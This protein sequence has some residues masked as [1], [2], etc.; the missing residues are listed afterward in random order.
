MLNGASFWSKEQ[1]D[2]HVISVDSVYSKVDIETEQNAHDKAYLLDVDASIHLEIM[3][4]EI[5][6]DGSAK[7]LRDEKD[8]NN[9]A[10]ALLTYRASKKTDILPQNTPMTNADMCKLING[11]KGPTHVVSSIV[12]GLRAHFIFDRK[13][14]KADY[15]QDI[16]GKLRIKLN[17]IPNFKLDAEAS[18]T[19]NETVKQENK[20]THITFYG[21]SIVSKMPGT[22]DQVKETFDEINQQAKDGN[23][24]TPIQYQLTPIRYYCEGIVTVLNEIRHSLVARA[25]SIL[26]ELTYTKTRVKTLLN[27]EPAIRFTSIRKQ[28]ITFECELS[29]WSSVFTENLATLLPDIKSGTQNDED[30]AELIKTYDESVYNQDKCGIFLDHRTR[31]INTIQLVTDKAHDA[32]SVVLSD[33]GAATDNKC[34]F[35]SKYATVY[36][37]YVLPDKDV[38]KE[39][40]DGNYEEEEG[41]TQKWYNSLDCVGEAGSQLN[42]FLKHAAATADENHCNLI[43]LD[44]ID[45]KDSSGK[46]TVIKIY[47]HGTRVEDDFIFPGAPPVPVCTQSRYSGF[48]FSAQSNSNPNSHVTGIQVTARRK[49]DGF[50]TEGEPTR[51]ITTT[52]VVDNADSFEISG[53]EPDMEYEVKIAYVIPL[54]DSIGP[55]SAFITCKTA[56]TS[57]PRLPYQSSNSQTDYIMISWREPLLRA[58]E[59]IDIKYQVTFSTIELDKSE[60]I[61]TDVD[62][63]GD[64]Y[65]G[66]KSTTRTGAQCANWA[67]DDIAATHTE[68]GNHEY[69]RNPD[70]DENGPWCFK[71]DADQAEWG[72]EA[73]YCDIPECSSLELSEILTIKEHEEWDGTTADFT[74]LDVGQLY[75]IT[76]RAVHN[77]VTGDKVE[78]LAATRPTPPSAPTLVEVEETSI[79]VSVDI[80]T[81]RMNYA[82]T[83]D[84]L[85]VEYCK[86]SIS[87]GVTIYGTSLT[88]TVPLTDVDA[89]GETSIKE[90][91]IQSLDSGSWYDIKSK[92]RVRTP[93]DVIVTELSPGILVETTR[94]PSSP[95]AP[96]VDEINAYI[97]TF[98]TQ[99]RL[100]QTSTNSAKEK[101]ADVTNVYS[102][103]DSLSG[104]IDDGKEAFNARIQ[105][106][107]PAT[108]ALMRLSCVKRGI[109]FSDY[110]SGSTNS[111]KYKFPDKKSDEFDCLQSC[112]VKYSRNFEAVRFTNNPSPDAGECVCLDQRS[113][114][115]TELNGYFTSINRFCWETLGATSAVYAACTEENTNLNGFDLWDTEAVASIVDCVRL[116]TEE[117]GCL[118]IVYKQ[119]GGRCWL[120]NSESD[121]TQTETGSSRISMT[122]LKNQNALM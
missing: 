46:D 39:F 94:D 44:K 92:V 73:D 50:Y 62:P 67:L 106:L 119:S 58:K 121:S 104:R 110:N 77:G 93:N 109:K 49:D 11:D 117:I 96:L 65:R 25:I 18:A 116:C 70:N 43:R 15:I 19:D 27:T 3:S 17:N 36:E 10:R 47:Q 64:F 2:S 113:G 4:G 59:D 103:Y 40:C 72:D 118:S 100:A 102:D 6:V 81:M 71:K 90:V 1:L 16:V 74:E 89:S 108:R 107:E 87:D 20:D 34:I 12:Y 68:V 99:A 115:I 54:V 60:C 111:Y 35:T 83:M 33:R 9:E 69:C 41:E 63:A 30:L 5:T 79:K 21:D 24:L 95:D 31:E 42:A 114:G 91:N 37:L 45:E 48:V 7:Y 85:I 14:G 98:D 82:F 57:A 61:D 75:D 101:L 120:K 29:E 53:L 28:L 97:D 122:C 56:A 26:S 51:Y 86:M 84:S 52:F 80:S 55:S 32:S 78:F 88:Q 22:Y 8:T 112:E 66:S 76:I 38:A 13:V 23:K 105:Q